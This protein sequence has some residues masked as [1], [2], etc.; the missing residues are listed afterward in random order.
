MPKSFFKGRFF[1]S[2]SV[3]SNPHYTRRITP[4]CVKG[5]GVHLRG[6]ESEQHSFEETLSVS[7]L[8]S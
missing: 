4:K 3:K 7:D 8:A 6:L 1:K 2:K 5:G